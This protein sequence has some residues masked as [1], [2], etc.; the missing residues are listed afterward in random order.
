MLPCCSTWLPIL[1]NQFIINNVL[2]LIFSGPTPQRFD[3]E[4]QENKKAVLAGGSPVKWPEAGSWGVWCG[5]VGIILGEGLVAE[6][7]W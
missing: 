7:G 2:A 1:V 4:G 3:K 5:G 6:A